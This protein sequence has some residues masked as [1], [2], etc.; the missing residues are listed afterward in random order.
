MLNWYRA[1]PVQV[2]DMDAPFAL[3]DGWKRFPLPRQT[4]PTLVIWAMD[5]IA[6]PPANLDGLDVLID[7]L[8]IAR[9]PGSGHFVQWEAPVEFNTALDAF[10]TR[11][12]DGN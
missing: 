1:S 12:A 10:L 11:T 9:I 4:I 7:D 2:F 6:L 3:P 8:T 5:D